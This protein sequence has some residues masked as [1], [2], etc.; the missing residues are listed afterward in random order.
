M[1]KY[2]LKDYPSWPYITDVED[3]DDINKSGYTGPVLMPIG[4]YMAQDQYAEAFLPRALDQNRQYPAG[5]LLTAKSRRNSLP[6]I[7]A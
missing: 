4:V 5:A 2:P 3:L 6:R 1:I 7:L